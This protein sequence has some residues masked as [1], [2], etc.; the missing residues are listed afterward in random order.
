M[1]SSIPNSDAFN[2]VI[3]PAGQCVKLIAEETKVASL[4]HRAIIALSNQGP[5]LDLVRKQFISENQTVNNINKLISEQKVLG[6]WAKQLLDED[7]DPIN[8]HG[9]I[10]LWVAV[11]VA[12]EDTAV[13]ILIK[14]QTAIELLRGAGIKVPNTSSKPLSES[15]ARRVYSRLERYSRKGKSVAEGYCHLMSV[16]GISI[17]L[18]KE[19]FQ[20]IAELNYVR[21]CLLHR[22]GVADERANIEAPTLGLKVG[23]EIKIPSNRYGYYF[24]AVGQFAQALL[25][26]VVHSKYIRV[27]K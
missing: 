17:N 25:H 23:E 2:W 21:N 10:G 5:L 4:L 27:K 8:K 20:T 7:F 1:L 12:V 16:L 3:G 6:P 18:P 26:G 13:L 9:I 24:E 22:A 15:E 19:A 11:E 14:D